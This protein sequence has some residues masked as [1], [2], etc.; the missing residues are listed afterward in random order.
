[1]IES[2]DIGTPFTAY[3]RGKCDHRGGGEDMMVL[4]THILDLQAFVFGPPQRVWAD[5]K[6]NGRPIV[7]SDRNETVEPIGPAAG[8]DV[9]ACLNYPNGVRGVFE[10][11]RGLPG[12]ADGGV[13]MGLTVVGTNGML[14]MR[15]NDAAA[16]ICSLRRARKSLP[17]ESGAEF[18]EVPL[19]ETRLTPG[20][21]PLDFSL[22]GQPDIPWAPRFLEANRFAVL[23]LMHAIEED[24]PPVS[25]G[26]TAR[27]TLEMIYGI[28]AASLSRKEIPL[29]LV[30]RDHP[31]TI[32]EH[33]SKDP[34]DET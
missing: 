24:R 30:S 3:G 10:S 12:I 23:D 33:S 11:R 17:L 34:R 9:F 4:G 8:D 29:P 5:V 13:Q 7:Q 1:M 19:V 14:S 15:F 18:E 16:P 27:T 28:Y 20:A 26:C 22:S 2:G 21:E 32:R 6:A 31:L 25:N